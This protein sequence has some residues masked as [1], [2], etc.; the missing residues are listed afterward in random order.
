MPFNYN[1]AIK[2]TILS[3]S[4]DIFSDAW[5]V[6]PWERVDSKAIADYKILS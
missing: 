4:Q 6:Y 5:I 2:S 3:M 1:N